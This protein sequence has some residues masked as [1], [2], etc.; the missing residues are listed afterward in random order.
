MSHIVPGATQ[1]FLTSY[2]GKNPFGKP[3]WRLLVG[4]DR[5]VKESG[6]YRDWA[7][8][9]STAEKGGLDFQPNPE[10]PGCN[11]SRHDNRPIRV[12]TEMREVRKYPHAEGWILEKWFP[13]SSYGTQAEWYSY[14][15]ID[16]FTPML[17]PYPECGDYEMVFGP[18]PKAPTTDT[19]QGLIAQYSFGINSR[20]GSAESRAQEYLLRFQY[21]EEQ[22]EA[23][24]KVEYDAM[25]RDHISPLHSSSLAASR[26]RQD[27]ARRT[28]NANEHIG[29]L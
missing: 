23:K 7:P 18:W 29:I 20:R 26:W 19:L 5:L 9:L 21:E 28:G 22:A 27:L 6:V 1:R 2:G 24:R 16:G 17:G 11:F 4:S 15:A 3:Q 13:A 10:A 12:V 25:M 8:G 14:K